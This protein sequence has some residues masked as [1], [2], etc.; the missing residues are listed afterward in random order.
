MSLETDS[1]DMYRIELHL[2]YST[3]Q[4]MSGANNHALFIHGS[5]SS[6]ISKA[7]AFKA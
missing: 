1:Y 6:L 3:G 7:E 2:F 5:S 4:S